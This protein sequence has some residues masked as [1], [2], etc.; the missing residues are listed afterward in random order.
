MLHS[1]LAS[2]R[3]KRIT[4]DPA[5]IIRMAVCVEKE[6]RVKQIY[7]LHTAPPTPDIVLKR[8]NR[9]PFLGLLVASAIIP[10]I[11]CLVY[12]TCRAIF[13]LRVRAAPDANV[14]TWMVLLLEILTACTKILMP[15]LSHGQSWVTFVSSA[16]EKV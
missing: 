3:R 13:T 5:S 11:T 1:G 10:M 9:S 12:L 15:N 16:D 6:K 2:N 4:A 7:H 14:V 8:P